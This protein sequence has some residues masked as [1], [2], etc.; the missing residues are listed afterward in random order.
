MRWGSRSPRFDALG[1]PVT[2][3]DP[4]GG[5]T[6]S[7][8]DA[9]GRLVSVTDANGDVE[10]F[11]YDALGR[12]TAEVDGEGFA[13]TQTYD[14]VGN[15]LTQTSPR[16]G[17]TQYVYDSMNRPV[18]V[19]NAEGETT[20]VLYDAAGNVVSSTDPVGVVKRYTYDARGLL[21]Q[22][23]ENAVTGAPADAV[24]NVTTS[25]AYDA[26]GVA[27]SV[28][29]ARGNTTVYQLDA[30][31]RV[32]ET[33]DALGRVT[34]AQFDAAGRMVAE[35]H[36]DGT[37]TG[38][39]FSADGFLVATQ[40][41]DRTVTYGVDGVGNRVSMADGVGT[42]AWAYDWAQRVLTDTDAKGNTHTYVYDAVGNQVQASL[43][44]G[45]VLTRGFD[46]RGLPVTQTDADGTTG[47]AY[48]A[49]GNLIEV[50][51][52]TGV[53]T[54][55]EFDLVGR[56]TNI[57]H[58]G[59]TPDG[60]VGEPTPASGAPG[61]AF[62]H[63]NGAPG[64]DNQEPTGCWTGD[65]EFAYDYDDRGLIVARSVTTDES[66]TTTEYVHD[67]L[68]RLTQSVT[69][70]FVAT[71]GWDAASNLVAESVSDDVNTNLADDG[72][73]AVRTVN[74]VNQLTQVVTDV[75]GPDVHTLTEVFTFDARGNR[76]GSVTSR[77]TGTK[78][79]VAARTDYVFD[80]MDQV[81]GVRDHGANLNNAKD[82]IVT[83]W[84]RDGF[85]RGLSVTE[86]G[87][88]RSRV[89]E[90]T[91][92]VADGGTRVT[93]APNG[94]VLSE[95]FETVIGHGS[96]AATVT[97]SRDVLTDVLGS[98]V[99]IGEEGIINA[100]LR[101]MGD[102]GDDLITPEWSTVTGFTGRTETAGLVE[103]A[104]RIYDP[105]DRVWV[106]EDAFAGSVTRASSMNRYAYVEGS[107]ISH[108]DVLGAYRAAA[109]M[110]Q[111]QLSA[112]DFAVFKWWLAL[113]SVI[114][115]HNEQVIADQYSAARNMWSQTAIMNY[116]DSWDRTTDPEAWVPDRSGCVVGPCLNAQMKNA[117]QP[118][119][120]THNLLDA[121][122]FLPGVGT[123]IDL[124]HGAMYA[125]KG[126]W[127]IA[128]IYAL[129]ALPFAGDFFAGTRIANKLRA[130][131]YSTR[132]LDSLLASVS[133][134]GLPA[135]VVAATL[136]N[137]KM[138]SRL[139]VFGPQVRQSDD[140][141]SRR[142]YESRARQGEASYFSVPDEMYR[143][144]GTQANILF[145]DIIAAK[146]DIVAFTIPRSTLERLPES[147]ATYQEMQ[148]LVGWHM[149]EWVDDYTLRPTANPWGNVFLGSE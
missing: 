38:Y 85:G 66:V 72:F 94:S 132:S 103:F 98:A 145:V 106:Q 99:A 70:Y 133:T 57:T 68:G 47:F 127:G 10:S 40:Y 90:G 96:K 146:K 109:A 43:S 22:T 105:A 95:A 19:T 21:T 61:N 108:V 67:A 54:S 52:P 104:S 39:E 26:R 44:D 111:Q 17:V 28:T 34:G 136:A 102:F 144:Y 73:S 93:L 14:A 142:S 138:E 58:S 53:V 131:A 46:G 129:S 121:G 48:D 9:A 71:Y 25:T 24:T 13:T 113:L 125:E 126:D 8:Y 140:L 149:Y 118:T 60:Y 141:L 77:T 87:A 32:V 120:L 83:T 114:G 115:V 49:D 1:R 147:S 55:T 51:R 82:D 107:P 78:T 122:G 134:R 65:L 7:A 88:T 50:S 89:F 119:Q 29:D 112:A 45:R 56:A 76:V 101:V 79:H 31:G 4:D 143:E 37:Q 123:I 2:V 100:D 33:T 35:L 62:G 6:A 139:T 42:S 91:T 137:V 124:G 3:T 128:A 15:V 116:D 41:T 64:H 135:D 84:S 130:G 63:C 18:S 117:M 74:A 23:V 30:L 20:A 69:G 12:T 11:A 86:S 59:G 97:I 75:R 5:V 27:V 110:A 80:G 16:G 81:V 148:R 92:V 36:A